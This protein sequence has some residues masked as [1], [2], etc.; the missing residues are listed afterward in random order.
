MPKKNIKKKKQQVHIITLGDST[1][2]KTCLISRYVYNVFSFSF[3]TIGFDTKLKDLKLDNGEEIKVILTDTAGQD[4]YRSI[5][6]NYIKKVD[7][8]Y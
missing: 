1:V 6:S 3:P 5:A 4:R 8:F 7:G 2:G